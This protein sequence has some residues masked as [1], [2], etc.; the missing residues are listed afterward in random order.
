M[1]SR[2]FRISAVLSKA[3]Q[4]LTVKST[5]LEVQDANARKRL[6]KP[7]P[8]RKASKTAF[9]AEKDINE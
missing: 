3:A 2:G 7:G 1:L 8:G 4:K 9:Y 6:R 5:Q